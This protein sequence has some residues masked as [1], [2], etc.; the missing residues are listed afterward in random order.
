MSVRMRTMRQPEKGARTSIFNLSKT[1]DEAPFEDTLRQSRS[2]RYQ[3]VGFIDIEDVFEDVDKDL[4][5]S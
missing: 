5:V 2:R 1:D 4:N 3:S